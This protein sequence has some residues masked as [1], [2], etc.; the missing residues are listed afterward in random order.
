M[1]DMNIFTVIVSFYASTRRQQQQQHQ[2]Q[3]PARLPPFFEEGR[4]NRMMDEEEGGV[5]TVLWLLLLLLLLLAMPPS[6]MH[7][8]GGIASSTPEKWKLP[9]T[10][11]WYAFVKELFYFHLTKVVF[12][13][14]WIIKVSSFI[15]YVE[16]NEFFC[17]IIHIR[18]V[19]GII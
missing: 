16:Q 8:E 12:Y 14:L 7:H 13:L 17:T 2:H 4:G 1:D 9:T 11:K 10:I 3:H 18:L 5:L 6:C 19:W 15:Q